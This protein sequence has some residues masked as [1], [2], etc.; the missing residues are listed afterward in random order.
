MFSICVKWRHRSSTPK[1]HQRLYRPH[2]VQRRRSIVSLRLLVVTQLTSPRRQAQVRG[3]DG[4][5]VHCEQVVVAVPLNILK[6]GDIEFQ[7]PLPEIM[8]RALG[9]MAMGNAV[10]VRRCV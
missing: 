10:K 6:A 4:R 3:R 2:R 5:V 9:A 8:Q 7:P 1:L